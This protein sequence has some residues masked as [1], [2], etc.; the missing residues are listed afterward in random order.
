M[1]GLDCAVL[2]GK[3]RHTLASEHIERREEALASLL[4]VDNI[5]NIAL[6]RGLEYAALCIFIFL[7]ERFPLFCGN[8]H[9]ILPYN[10]SAGD[11]SKRGNGSLN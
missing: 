4:R 10:G 5:F 2:L 3:C 9:F 8:I 1:T 7:D 6:G 11:G